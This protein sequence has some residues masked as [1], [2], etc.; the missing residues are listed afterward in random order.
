M[1]KV[2]FLSMFSD[3][4]HFTEFFKTIFTMFYGV[5][6]GKLKNFL[7]YDGCNLQYASIIF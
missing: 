2:R 1:K 5:A 6:A 4:F 3:F 7:N